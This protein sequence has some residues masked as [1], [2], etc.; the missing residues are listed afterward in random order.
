MIPT[1]PQPNSIGGDNFDKAKESLESN[2][3][4][5]RF[6]GNQ[7]LWKYVKPLTK[8]KRETNGALL[9]TIPHASVFPIAKSTVPEYKHYKFTPDEN[10]A[11]EVSHIKAH[12]HFDPSCDIFAHTHQTIEPETQANLGEF[13]DSPNLVNTAYYENRMD[14]FED[15]NGK[16]DTNEFVQKHIM[17]EVN[18]R[19]EFLKEYFD[20]EPITRVEETEEENKERVEKRVEKRKSKYLKMKNADKEIMKEYKVKDAKEFYDI[21]RAKTTGVEIKAVRR[22][23]V[24]RDSKSMP[25]KTGTFIHNQTQSESRTLK[26]SKTRGTTAEPTAEPKTEPKTKPKTESKTQADINYERTEAER[27][28]K[29]QAQIDL[30]NK[31]PSSRSE[32]Y[33]NASPLALRFGAEEVKS[34][35]D[36]KKITLEEYDSLMDSLRKG[37][38]KYPEK[39]KKS[40]NKENTPYPSWLVKESAPMSAQ[41]SATTTMETRPFTSPE[42]VRKP[43]QEEHEA[44]KESPQERDTSKTRIDKE[45]KATLKLAE[46]EW[47]T[48]YMTTKKFNEIKQKLRADFRE[49]HPRAK[50]PDVLMDFDPDQSKPATQLTETKEGGR[51]LA[52]MVDEIKRLNETEPNNEKYN[53]RIDKL[54]KEYRDTGHQRGPY[55]AYLRYKG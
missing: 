11:F 38:D 46:G 36:D 28:K 2:L 40:I 37:Y 35:F 48:G 13:K 43:T 23:A 27:E 22:D 53:D 47:G 19:D 8:P 42:K 26:T 33:E 34:E 17:D 31:P 21:K 7:N 9:S 12:F 41:M 16:F 49:I 44:R 3:R 5:R 55:P 39:T 15:K 50:I 4:F 25:A 45:I 14:R 18:P 29:R 10:K 51:S 1:Q 20:N 54:R 6:A 52:D 32:I 24:R 30:A